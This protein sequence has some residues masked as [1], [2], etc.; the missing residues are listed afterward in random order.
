MQRFKGEC[1]YH[2]NT[3]EKYVGYSMVYDE[4]A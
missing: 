2:E 3:G 1:V 4:K